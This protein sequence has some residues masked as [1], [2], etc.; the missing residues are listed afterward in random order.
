[1]GASA[2]G[3]GRQVSIRS[4]MLPFS[5]CSSITASVSGIIV[6]RTGSYRPMMWFGWS[7]MTLGWGLMIMLDNTT[8]MKSNPL[9]ASLGIGCVF[10]TPL[11]AIQAAMPLKDM[12]YQHLSVLRTLGSTVG[13]TIGETIISSVLPQKLKGIKGLTIDTSAAALN[14]NIKWISSISVMHA[15]TRTP[16]SGFGFFLVS[17]YSCYSLKRT[18]IRGGENK[19]ETLRLLETLETLETLEMHKK[20]AFIGDATRST[21]SFDDIGKRRIEAEDE[22]KDFFPISRTLRSSY[23]MEIETWKDV[24]VNGLRRVISIDT[25]DSEQAP[26]KR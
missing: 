25:M 23:Y 9:I 11:I 20:P 16:L 8:T 26:F 19:L 4:I 1:L 6:A 21:D 15:Y 17:L 2:T 3:S 10:Q 24:W 22:G 13:M 18:V 12:A 5:L 7:V 14:G